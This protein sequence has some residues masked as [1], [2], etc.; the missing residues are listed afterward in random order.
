SLLLMP[1]CSAMVPSA[2][3][4]LARPWRSK[5]PPRA[6]SL[7][8][9]VLKLCRICARRVA[10][11]LVGSASSRVGAEY[12]AC[13]LQAPDSRADYGGTDSGA[14]SVM[15]KDAMSEHYHDAADLRLLK[16]MRKLAP[17]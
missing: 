13:S 11:S 14:G 1:V 10:R 7:C 5:K 3:R 16:E 9:A 4:L 6:K 15:R 17:D 2:R 12:S 8:G